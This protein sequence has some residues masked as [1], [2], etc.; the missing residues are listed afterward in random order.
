MTHFIESFR[1]AAI[2]LRECGKERALSVCEKHAV[3]MRRTGDAAGHAAWQFIRS[4]VLD[5]NRRHRRPG[6]ALH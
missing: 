3:A 5:L 2:L 6:E 4:A 1:A